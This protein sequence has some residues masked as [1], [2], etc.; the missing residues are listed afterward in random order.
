[1]S[2]N[3]PLTI[4]VIA[5]QDTELRHVIASLVQNLENQYILVERGEDELGVLHVAELAWLP[6]T[7]TLA[8]LEKYFLPTYKLDA[9]GLTTPEIN[10]QIDAHSDKFI[11]LYENGEFQSLIAGPDILGRSARSCILVRCKTCTRNVVLCYGVKRC[12]IC[13]G[14]AV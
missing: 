5:N 12:P 7:K 11:L 9:T 13:Q 8:D 10:D 14:D 4:S 1:M 3:P 6:Y 2:S